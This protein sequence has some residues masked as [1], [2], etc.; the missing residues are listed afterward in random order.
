MSYLFSFRGRINRAKMWLFILVTLA[1]EIV[2]GLVASLGLGWSRQATFTYDLVHGT[3][4]TRIGGLFSIPDP[5]SGHLQWAAAGIVAFLVLLYAVALF[6]V[7][8]K[9]LHDRNRNAWW[10]LPF[11]VIPCGLEVLECVAS[12]NLLAMG[13]YFGPFG[14][15]VGAAD[16]V[17]S[18]LILWAIIELFFFRGTAGENRYGSDPLAR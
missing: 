4:R 11:V 1:F 14:M 7:V 3:S 10:L 9:R 5:I 18:I 16:L 15:D 17:A 8:T 12:P 6:S 2:I 13:K